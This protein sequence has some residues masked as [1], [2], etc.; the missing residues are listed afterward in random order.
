MTQVS[1]KDRVAGMKSACSGA[2]VL[3]ALVS[4]AFGAEPPAD[5]PATPE[6]DFN[7]I[8]I[9]VDTLRAD[10]LGCYGYDRRPSSPNVDALARD[11]ILFESFITSCPWTTP[12]HLSMLTSLQ[13]VS[14]GLT[15]SFGELWSALNRDR[16]Y[17]KLPESRVTLAEVLQSHGFRTVAFTAGG[18]LA[19]KIGFSQGFDE[20]HSTMYKLNDDNV[21]QMLAW[22][23][24]NSKQ[25]FFLFWHHFEVHAPYLSAEFVADVLSGEKAGAVKAGTEEIAG[26]PLSGV[27]PSGAATRLRKQIEFLKKQEAFNAEVCESLYVGGVR[28]ADRWLGKLL[29]FLRENGLYDRTMIVFTSDHGDEFA[30]H[31]GRRFYNIH[32]HILYE[33][34]VRVP[35]IVKLPAQAHAGV[36]VK[37]VS[38]MI[39]LMPTVLDLVGARPEKDE[40]QGASLRPCWTLSPG[41][42]GHIAITE[43]CA[44]RD[45]K[46]SVRTDRYKYI[47]SLAAETVS[48]HGRA[49]LPEAPPRQ[50]LYDLLEDPLERKNLLAGPHEEEI[51]VLAAEFY[52]RLRRYISENRGEAEPTTL[53]EET[54]EKIRSLGYVGD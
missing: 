14:H 38:R 7:V 16:D 36:R 2:V 41:A 26:L 48:E 20:Y 24:K 17:F 29:G 21:G 39:D 51:D 44:R 30:D 27:W 12:A 52:E 25:R 43:G 9:S 46:K 45:E 4:V 47:V 31:H 34:M 50:E 1:R 32:G 11:G 37:A 54:Y 23:E 53:D 35:L 40:M 6:K 5:S 18:P 42:P 13:P 8:L 22:I 19:G 15:A 49:Y 28:S 3:L 10:R 33:E